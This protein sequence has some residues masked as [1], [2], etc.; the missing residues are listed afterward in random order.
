MVKRVDPQMVKRATTAGKSGHT[1]VARAQPTAGKN[2]MRK[3]SCGKQTAGSE[4][5]KN[6]NDSSNAIQRQGP[7]LQTSA[8]QQVSG[9]PITDHRAA[10][11]HDPEG[12]E[13]DP[14]FTDAYHRQDRSQSV[15][16][17]LE[18]SQHSPSTETS[19]LS[20]SSSDKFLTFERFR[21]PARWRFITRNRAARSQKMPVLNES[22]MP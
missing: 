1:A 21:T 3:D 11:L 17:L 7:L 9:G 6:N 5:L 18:V 16:K 13:T 4:E 12:P 15:Q 20:R 19:T 8:V 22:E 10:V 14:S 2:P